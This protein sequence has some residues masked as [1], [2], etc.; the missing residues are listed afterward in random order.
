[1]DGGAAIA[2]S[3]ASVS[4]GT[5][6]VLKCRKC[7][8]GMWKEP[9]AMGS[10]VATGGFET[11]VTTSKHSGHGDGGSVFHGHRAEVKCLDCG[12]KWFT[13]HPSRSGRKMHNEK[14]CN[15]CQGL[16]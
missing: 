6:L 12:H 9:R 13:T 16:P 11:R 15:I 8:R 4:R 1:M 3:E 5:P 7:K 2:E 14:S 10:V